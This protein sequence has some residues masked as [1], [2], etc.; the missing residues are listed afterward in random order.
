M[1]PRRM[2]PR[3]I[4]DP[5]EVEGRL[6]P[7]AV[8]AGHPTVAG[9]HLGLQQH[10]RS[11]LAQ[12]SHPLGRLHVEHPGVVE[13]GHGEHA[14]VSHGAHVL[15]GGVAAHIG[16]HLRVMQRIT[17]LVPFDHG[18][19]QRGV[20]DRGQ[21][22]HERHPGE[23][24]REQLRGQVRHGAHQQAAGAA[25]LGDEPV[26]GGEALIDQVPGAVNEVREAVALV[27]LLAVLVPEPTQFAAAAHM[28]DR[29]DQ[30]AV[31]QTEPGDAER[32]VDADLVGAVAVEQ[33]WRRL[34]EGDQVAAVDQGDRNAGA[35]G[36]GGPLAALLEQAR[37]VAAEHGLLLP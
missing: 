27:Q 2:R 15:H 19:R 22:V 21:R 36:G 33:G 32:R 3:G 17:P 7:A 30:A 4:D 25:A 31:E 34:A 23:D 28:G 18:Q 6:T 35:V 1:R 29:E 26:R 8:P 14:G 37:V 5:G 16:V 20:Q 13:A 12:P 11:H 10:I 9:G 24:A